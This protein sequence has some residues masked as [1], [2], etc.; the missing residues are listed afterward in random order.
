MLTTCTE[1][2]AKISTKG[3]K[4]PKCGAPVRHIGETI[5]RGAANLI[6]MLFALIV[7]GLIVFI[8]IALLL[9]DTQ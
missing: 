1:C 6:K 9:R 7:L 5:A 3:E 2:K 8:V 4:C